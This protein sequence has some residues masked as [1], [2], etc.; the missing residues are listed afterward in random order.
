MAFFNPVTDTGKTRGTP[1]NWPQVIA[2][3]S[4]PTV[5]VNN[6][7]ELNAAAATG[8]TAGKKILLRNGGNWSGD[9]NINING[10]S[11][12]PVL[13]AAENP[14]GWDVRNVSK[15]ASKVFL[16]SQYLIFGALR[17]T[18]NSGALSNAFNVFGSDIRITDFEFQ[19]IA[20]TTASGA[21]RMFVIHDTAHRLRVDHSRFK[22]VDEYCFVYDPNG[23]TGAYAQNVICEY[24]DFDDVQSEYLQIGQLANPYQENDGL[25]NTRVIFR[26]NFINNCQSAQTKS[27]GNYI[28]RNYF[29][30]MTTGVAVTLRA[31]NGNIVEANYFKDCLRPIRSFAED[32]QI[33]HNVFDGAVSA[34]EA[35]IVFLEGSLLNQM[36]SGVPSL[37]VPNAQHVRCMGTLVA[38]NTFLNP[39]AR[40]VYIGRTQ[41]GRQQTASSTGHYEP[42]SPKNLYFMNNLLV[43]GAGVGFYLRDPNTSIHPND[44]YPTTTAVN[45]N[46]DSYHIYRGLRFQGNVYHLTGTA[47]LGNTAAA[48]RISWTDATRTAGTVVS[49]NTPAN[50]ALVDVYRHGAGSP[51]IDA[52]VAFNLA[53]Y[54]TGTAL[55]WDGNPASQGAGPD[56]GVMEFSAGVG[57]SGR[58]GHWG[59]SDYDQW[60]FQVHNRSNVPEKYIW[61]A[62]GS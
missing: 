52:G 29:T 31:G 10:T 57:N 40:A 41:T 39:M 11:T 43:M 55:D 15:N 54:D 12:Q 46:A 19:D 1:I 58:S 60:G 38:R 33:I 56:A 27:I 5:Y 13:I 53:G 30:N 47:V 23:V 45:P 51:C 18:W 48:G 35:A 26:Y 4:G 24:C 59:T 28:G 44:P 21:P 14:G 61:V 37:Y 22:N 36:D 7:T 8:T 32:Q 9:W 34:N 25:V 16:R 2:A 42:Y 50:P 3:L 6:T 20:E 49:N 62:I 17:Y